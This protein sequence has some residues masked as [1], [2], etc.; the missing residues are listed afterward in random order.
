MRLKTSQAQATVKTEEYSATKK[1]TTK[2]E[3]FQPQHGARMG[4]GG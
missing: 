2:K 3:F 4:C 1:N